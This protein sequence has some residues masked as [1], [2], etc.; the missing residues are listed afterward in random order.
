MVQPLHGS[1]L[2][3][4]N[5]FWF[6]S[7]PPHIYAVLRIGLGAVG[8]LTLI[9]LGDMTFWDLDSGFIADNGLVAFKAAMR[10]AG[11][12]A[13]AGWVMYSICLAAFFLMTIGLKS[14]F[15]VPFAL[16][17]QLVQLSWN[18]LP[19]SG[20]HPTMQSILF[21]LMWADTGAVLS[22]DA[23]LER[24]RGDPP[25]ARASI[26]PLRLI[27]YQIALIYF[28]TGL[29][30]LLSPLWRDGSAVHYV[31]NSNVFHRFPNVL[32]PNLEWVAVVATYLTLFWELGFAVMVL[33]RPTRYLALVL[34]IAMHLGML[35]TIEIGPFHFVMLAAYPAFLEPEFVARLLDPLDRLRGRAPAADNA[36][37]TVA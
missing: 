37:S 28:V 31:L 7:I 25:T 19:L 10:A 1:P 2:E 3:R 11:V 23:W 20:A 34:G 18:G 4:W 6:A 5:Q 30:K 35:F 27:R 16:I 12:G 8:F 24:R 36:L 33:W 13:V 32:P 21:C 17:T 22:V 26:A 15:A 29:W 9:R 14:S